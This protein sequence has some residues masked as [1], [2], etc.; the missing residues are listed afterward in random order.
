MDDVLGASLEVDA[1]ADVDDLLSQSIVDMEVSSIVNTTGR[2]GIVLAKGDSSM[3]EDES[4]L[5]VMLEVEVELDSVEVDS[6]EDTILSRLVSMVELTSDIY[7][8]R[9]RKGSTLPID[10]LDNSLAV[11]VFP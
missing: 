10:W 7:P 3:S 8:P 11:F 9:N 6:P 2:S 4:V 5:I 1:S